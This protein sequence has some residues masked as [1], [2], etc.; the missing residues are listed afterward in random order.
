MW[1]IC[2]TTSGGRSNFRLSWRNNHTAEHPCHQRCRGASLARPASLHGTHA[3][4]R[5]SQSAKWPVRLTTR[6]MHSG[7]LFGA[8]GTK[9]GPTF[10]SPSRITDKRRR[11]HRLFLS[12]MYIS[13]GA[14][15]Y[16]PAV[17]QMQ[18]YSSPSTNQ[19]LEAQQP[20]TLDNPSGKKNTFQSLA[21][22]RGGEV[23]PID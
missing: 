7:H 20:I 8:K 23:G 12:P 11:A 15:Q 14:H 13:V 10:T 19:P 2:D 21:M 5:A 17:G 1:I 18:T 9:I 4:G 6:E 3:H 16:S 22:H